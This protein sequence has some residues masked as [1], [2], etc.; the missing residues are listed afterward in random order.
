MYSKS[1]F[2][3]RG[4]LSACSSSPPAHNMTIYKPD[5]NY[6]RYGSLA[7]LDSDFAADH[8]PERE[9]ELSRR[10]TS[11]SWSRGQN[12]GLCVTQTYELFL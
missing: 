2:R 4:E 12:S 9:V 1:V 11:V 5:K 3:E 8:P 7:H 10:R 6:W